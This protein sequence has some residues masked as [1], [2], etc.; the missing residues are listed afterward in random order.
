MD[1]RKWLN[2]Y[3]L[4]KAK[5]TSI[6]DKDKINTEVAELIEGYDESLE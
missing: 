5:I 6:E 3:E 4:K 1:V 2:Y